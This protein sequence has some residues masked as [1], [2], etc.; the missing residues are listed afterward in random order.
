MERSFRRLVIGLA[1]G[2]A[3]AAVVASAASDCGYLSRLPSSATTF[4][5]ANCHDGASSYA[6][7]TGAALNPFGVAF[8]Q[9]G[10]LWDDTLAEAN[11]DGDGCSNGV[12]LGDSNGDGTP[13]RNVTQQTTNPGV[14]GDCEAA[15]TDEATWGALKSLFNTN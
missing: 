7:P 1:L 13:D 12:E 14:D 9:N 11:A 3:V 4:G 10:L 8:Q 5:C 6:V 2:L 15:S